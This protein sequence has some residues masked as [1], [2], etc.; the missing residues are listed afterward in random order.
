V[1]VSTSVEL[2][3]EAPPVE[4]VPLLSK[5]LVYPPDH[6]LYLKQTVDI[7][8][9]KISEL[10][11]LSNKAVLKKGGRFMIRELVKAC[12]IDKSINV[13]TMIQADVFAIL[14]GIRVVSFGA[15]YPAEFVC[16][17]CEAKNAEHEFDLSKLELKILETQ[18]AVDSTN[19]FMFDL[20]ATKKR[21]LFKLLTE[22]E[23]EEIEREEEAAKKKGYQL[24]NSVTTQLLKQMVSID[25]NEDRTF[26]AK[27]VQNMPVR[28]L[29]ALRKYITSVEPSIVMKQE[30]SCPSC[31]FTDEINVPINESFL[32]PT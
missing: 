8:P 16:P 29:M 5:G 3:I 11:M 12:M 14:M 10:D 25:G 26:I 22:N 32:F 27:F 7:R 9:M 15:N 24:S 28:D 21:L 19:I 30:V 13:G 2:G 17:Q 20:P 6:P 18:P 31:D 4:T 23:V 1:P